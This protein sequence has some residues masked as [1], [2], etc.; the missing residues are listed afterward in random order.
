M[1][2][3]GLLYANLDHDSRPKRAFAVFANSFEFMAIVASSR[4]PASYRIIAAADKLRSRLGGLKWVFFALRNL[5]RFR[6]DVV[7]AEGLVAL[8][9]GAVY[10]RLT[11]AVLVYDARELYLKDEYGQSTYASLHRLV[12]RILISSAAHVLTANE[13][14]AAIMKRHYRLS[15]EPVAIHNIPAPKSSVPSLPEEFH[16][17][18]ERGAKNLIYQGRLGSLQRRGLDRILAAL[19]RCASPVRLIVIADGLG[20]QALR[21]EVKRLALESRVRIHDLVAHDL[22]YSVLRHCHLGLVCYELRGPNNNYCAPNKLYEYAQCE[23]PLLATPQATFAEVFAKYG[24]GRTF[25]LDAWQ[26]CRIEDLARQIEVSLLQPPSADK[27]RLFNRDFNWQNEERKLLTLIQD[28][29][30]SL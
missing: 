25:T 3:A 5:F 16:Y 20:A 11:S 17:L 18:L 7:L 21:F 28:I 24:V 10:S 12:E 4:Q 26:S 8:I 19:T 15:A 1:K 27:F 6:P 14:R 2:C 23:L 30:G 9:P 13:A 22:L 29:K